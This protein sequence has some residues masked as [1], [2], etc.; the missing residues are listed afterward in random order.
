[1]INADMITIVLL[2]SGLATGLILFRALK[3]VMAHQ[4]AD[5]LDEDI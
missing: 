4:F 1:M 2:L 5:D 3:N